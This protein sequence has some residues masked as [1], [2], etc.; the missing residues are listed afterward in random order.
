MFL[1]HCSKRKKKNVFGVKMIPVQNNLL[2]PVDGYLSSRIVEV[3]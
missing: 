2:G 3:K 1:N